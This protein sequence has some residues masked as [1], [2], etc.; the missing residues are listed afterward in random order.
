MWQPSSLMLTENVFVNGA[1]IKK[2]IEA[3]TKNKPRLPGAG[4]PVCNKE[5]DEKLIF[6]F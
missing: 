6:W 4:R 1:K 5:I 2:A 3:E